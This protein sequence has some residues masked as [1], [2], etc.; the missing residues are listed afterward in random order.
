MGKIPDRIEI[1]FWGF[2]NLAQINV[3]L[4]QNSSLRQ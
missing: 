1:L 3:R 2:R 4:M